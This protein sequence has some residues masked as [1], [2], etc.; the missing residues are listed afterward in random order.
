MHCHNYLH[1]EQATIKLNQISFKRSDKNL[2]R[3]RQ[4]KEA[5]ALFPLWFVNAKHRHTYHF[6][7]HF[8]SID[9]LI[10]AAMHWNFEFSSTDQMDMRLA[11]SMA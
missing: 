4:K 7:L 2:F 11:R 3:R 10:S 1:F 8:V 5:N 6:L 9:I